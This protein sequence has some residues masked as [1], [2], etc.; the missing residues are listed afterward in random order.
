MRDLALL[1]NTLIDK[2][3]YIFAEC[4]EDDP[5]Y[6]LLERDLAFARINEENI[7]KEIQNSKMNLA[8]RTRVLHQ[9]DQL[10]KCHVCKSPLTAEM[11]P[12]QDFEEGV[13][14]RKWQC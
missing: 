2:R 1:Q 13:K 3:E 10:A 6:T 11:M 8:L 5:V 7:N 12:R 4:A 9:F 14:D